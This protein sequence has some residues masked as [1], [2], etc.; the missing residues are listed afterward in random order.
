MPP[1]GDAGAL[2][3]P[4]GARVLHIG[5]PKTGTTALQGAFWLAR[6]A[7][8]RQGVRYPGRSRHPARPMFAVTRRNPPGASEPPP[9][10]V[11]DAFLA[12]VRQDPGARVMVSSEGFAY[13]SEEAITRVVS[14]LG[15]DRIQV[16]VT[17]RPLGRLLASEWQQQ[18]QGGMR[19]AFEAWLEALFDDP[20]AAHS[21]SFWHRHRHDRLVARWAAAAGA[22]RVTVLVVDERD[23]GKLYRDMEALLGLQA[24]TLVPGSTL[25]NRSL[26]LE[27]I[28]A[29]RALREVF[30]AEGRT[31]AEF[32]RLVRLQ[33]GPHL[34][35]RVPGPDEHRIE[36][37]AWALERA[38]AV[39]AE[40]V[41]AL[42]ASG[43]RWWGD[44]DGLAA[45]A[46]AGA[47]DHVTSD[48]P[49][50][51][52]VGAAIAMAVARAG[53]LVTPQEGDTGPADPA[54]D[55]AAGR[56]RKRSLVGRLGA[57]AAR[58]LGRQARTLGWAGPADAAV[59]ANAGV[60]GEATTPTSWSGAPDP[61]TPGP[62]PA[63]RARPG[64]AL[65]HQ[66]ST[67]CWHR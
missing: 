49:V 63:H 7:L 32:D 38:A 43:V 16:V 4:A 47:P 2:L 52:H 48:V 29:L 21:R 15:P 39:A 23:H 60:S 31:A 20:A 58:R 30:A 46:P 25:P 28:S 18:V 35:R 34:K 50:P 10:K 40:M 12:D 24:G 51:A 66:R 11:W 5:P 44:L 61:A 37:P 22:E 19:L 64:R 56:A 9:A 42:A 27:E 62:P 8:P 36:T 33:A 41:P 3:V 57:R 26:T 67:P 55:D 6:D 59:P 1:V 54:P 13:A 14:D 53:G 17:L 45:P 65:P